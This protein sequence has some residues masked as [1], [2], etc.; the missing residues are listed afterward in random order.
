MNAN[1]RLLLM[2]NW[3]ALARALRGGVLGLLVLTLLL[4]FP[5]A[6]RPE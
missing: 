5:E 3:S 2:V 1:G 6:Y 4:P